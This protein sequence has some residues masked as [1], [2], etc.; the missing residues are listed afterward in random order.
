MDVVS[1]LSEN[2]KSIIR[3]LNHLIINFKIAPARELVQ[4]MPK[5]G[6]CNLSDIF[7]SH[8]YIYISNPSAKTHFFLIVLIC[9]SDRS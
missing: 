9:C 8:I 7:R 1:A 4:R 3:W 2:H 6:V 5:S